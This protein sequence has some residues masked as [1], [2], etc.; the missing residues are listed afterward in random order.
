[1]CNLQSNEDAM[2]NNKLS[3]NKGNDCKLNKN[4]S[5]DNG[6]KFS[7]KKKLDDKCTIINLDDDDIDDNLNDNDKNVIVN[8]DK[9]K[10]DE[11]FNNKIDTIEKMNHDE[12]V[13]V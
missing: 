1:M 12:D 10:R 13:Y 3:T 7:F 8:Q 11:V 2:V 5:N 9:R 4:V 6:F